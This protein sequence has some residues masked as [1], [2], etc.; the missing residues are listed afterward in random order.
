MLS[1]NSITLLKDKENIIEQL[2][3]HFSNLFNRHITIDL[4]A[5]DL[6]PKKATLDTLVVLPFLDE[7][8]KVIK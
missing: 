7:I 5:L 4:T 3:E 8:K 1:L 6:I 2:R